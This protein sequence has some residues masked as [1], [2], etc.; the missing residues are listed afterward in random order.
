MQRDPASAAQSQPVR[1]EQRSSQTK[2]VPLD[3][4]MFQS[5]AGGAPK[6]TWLEPAATTNEDDFAPKGTW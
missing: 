5:V 2:P 6:G 1:P 3:P 4:K